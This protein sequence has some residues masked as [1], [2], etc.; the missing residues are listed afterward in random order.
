M[1]KPP[2]ATKQKM[3]GVRIPHDLHTALR[4]IA[5]SSNVKLQDLLEH[6]LRHH[7]RGNAIAY[8]DA[9]KPKPKT[10]K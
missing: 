5:I 6:V 2:P 8:K 9:L 7:V 3:V 4:A 1:S 10:R